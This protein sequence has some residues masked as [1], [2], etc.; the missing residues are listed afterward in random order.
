MLDGGATPPPTL[1]W[2]RVSGVGSRPG[3]WGEG[4]GWG[5]LHQRDGSQVAVTLAIKLTHTGLTERREVRR[6][7]WWS[8]W[9]RTSGG[10]MVG[11]TVRL[12]VVV[13]GAVVGSFSWRRFTWGQ[14]LR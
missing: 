1:P 14:V 11:A 8:S 12:V 13:L 3:L 9:W 6:S 5:G 2:V 10:T 7:P 4:G